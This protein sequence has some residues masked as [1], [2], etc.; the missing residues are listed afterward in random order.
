MKLGAIRNRA[1]LWTIFVVLCVASFLAWVHKQW[2]A[3]AEKVVAKYFEAIDWKERGETIVALQPIFFSQRS[4]DELG[5]SL[6]ELS[7]KFGSIRSFSI[8]FWHTHSG[9]GIAG[10]G[11]YVVLHC[12]S[13]YSKAS[14]Q[15]DFTLFKHFG[16]LGFKIVDHGFD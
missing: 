12:Q 16:D 13:V 15:E 3:E 8:Y 11:T 5:R 9:S 1:L 7:A 2:K 10:N 4:P 14:A 6:D